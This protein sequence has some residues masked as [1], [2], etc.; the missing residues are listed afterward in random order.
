MIAEI[1]QIDPE[2]IG[3]EDAIALWDKVRKQRQCFDDLTRDRGDVFA[4]RILNAATACFQT[5]DCLVLVE[6]IIPKLS[7]EIHFYI[8][9]PM[10]QADM[11]RYAR[12]ILREMFET[13]QLHRIS[14]YP[15]A[16]NQTAQ[17]MAVRLGF[18]WEGNIRQQ[19]LYEGRYHDVLVY[20]LLRQE[21]AALGG[22]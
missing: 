20:G 6:S 3:R 15:P 22:R 1:Q 2:K 8:W 14:A 18:K 11:L 5:E 10:R 13:H 21:F 19:F 4:A 16:F 17:R 12:A 9:S 7:A